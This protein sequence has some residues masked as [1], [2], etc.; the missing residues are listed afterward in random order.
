MQKSLLILIFFSVFTCHACEVL[1]KEHTLTWDTIKKFCHE[2]YQEMLQQPDS[3]LAGCGLG[4]ILHA[5]HINPAERVSNIPHLAAGL[6]IYSLYKSE[7]PDTLIFTI[8]GRYRESSTFIYNSATMTNMLAGGATAYCVL[9]I[10]SS[11]KS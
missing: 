7:H 9:S 1:R 10:I 3:F 6:A 4:T 5:S 2:T 8:N 11:L